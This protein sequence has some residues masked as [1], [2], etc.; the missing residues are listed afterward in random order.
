[1]A[2]RTRPHYANG[3]PPLQNGDHRSE[4]EGASHATLI[5]PH[6]DDENPSLLDGEQCI[7]LSAIVGEPPLTAESPENGARNA[8]SN[9]RYRGPVEGRIDRLN[10]PRRDGQNRVGG[11]FGDDDDSGVLPAAGA[12]AL[13]LCVITVAV[14]RRLR[15][16]RVQPMY[17]RAALMRSIYGRAS[18]PWLRI[19]TYGTA[20]DFIVSINVTKSLLVDKLLPLFEA[21]RSSVNFGGPYRH[22]RST[23]GRSAQLASIDLLGLALWFL[24][25]R[26]TTYK[27]CPIFG[28]VPATLA[29]WL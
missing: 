16:T 13:S 27:L 9:F 18:T 22:G 8:A 17:R 1:M 2:G 29:V 4:I 14:R 23:R 11:N 25:S 3:D 19:L 26:C 10:R 28:V 6:Y 21:E 7:A 5:M 24:K 15:A 20:A 12:A